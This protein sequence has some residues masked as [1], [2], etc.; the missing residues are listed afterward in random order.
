MRFGRGRKPDN[1]SR[2]FWRSVTWPKMKLP[3]SAEGVVDSLLTNEVELILVGGYASEHHKLSESIERKDYD[4]IISSEEK[5]LNLIFNLL[6]K[7]YDINKTIFFSNTLNYLKLETTTKKIDLIKKLIGR[8]LAK[9]YE[10][11]KNRIVKEYYS[12]KE[13]DYY[14]LK[15]NSEKTNLNGNIIYVMGKQDYL[16]SQHYKPST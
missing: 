10:K 11:K 7:N 8:P 14:T 2:P 5:N 9:I 6:N 3:I 4:F 1:W 13:F 12:L 15:K 16:D